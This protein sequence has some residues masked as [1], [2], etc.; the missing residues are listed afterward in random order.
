MPKLPWFDRDREGYSSLFVN[1]EGGY[2]DEETETEREPVR[3]PEPAAVEVIGKKGKGR[4]STGAS[5]AEE[6][7]AWP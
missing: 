3:S 2:R 4:A 7:T 1:P 6:S 5:G